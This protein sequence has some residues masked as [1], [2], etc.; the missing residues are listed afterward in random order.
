MPAAPNFED[1]RLRPRCSVQGGKIARW[2]STLPGSRKNKEHICSR[3]S[4]VLGTRIDGIRS[5]SYYQLKLLQDQ[6]DWVR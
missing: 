5:L 3:S 4:D 6:S 1:V 2:I